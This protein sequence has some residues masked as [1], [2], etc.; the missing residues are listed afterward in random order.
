MTIKTLTII[1]SDRMKHIEGLHGLVARDGAVHDATGYAPH[2]AGLQSFCLA[3]DG[4][5]QLAFQEHSHLLVRMAVRLDDC[6]RLELDERK[7]HLLSGYRE[8]VNAGKDLVM[9]RIGAGDEVGH[10]KRF[11][12][13]D[14]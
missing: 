6:V 9:R 11:W 14:L 8:N 7:H 12:I 1:F 10:G 13:L 4:E 3:A 5:R 2:F